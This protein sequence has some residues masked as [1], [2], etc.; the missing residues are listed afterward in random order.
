MTLPVTI[1]LDKYKLNCYHLPIAIL[2]LN[3][4]V[5][6]I[7]SLKNYHNGFNINNLIKFATRN[8]HSA[9]SNKVQQIRSA[10]ITSKNFYFNH[11]PRIWNILPIIDL[12]G[13][14]TRIKS[15]LSKY[16]W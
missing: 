15:K 1:N 10:N 2:D 12:N 6:F 16:L 3:D 9:L 14:P 8:T 5:F 13:H 11:L 7:K 4:V